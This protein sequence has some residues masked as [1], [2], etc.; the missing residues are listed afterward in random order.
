MLLFCLPRFDP[1]QETEFLKYAKHYI[2]DGL[3]FCRMM[4]EAGSFSSLAE[5][6]RVRQIGAMYNNSG[7]SARRS[8]PS[9]PPKADI[10]TKADLRTI[11]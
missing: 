8:F 3:L 2:Q 1:A 5:Y 4:G 6:R 9:S 10:R 7:K 11:C